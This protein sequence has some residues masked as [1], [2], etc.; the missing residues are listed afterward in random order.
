MPHIERAPAFFNFHNNKPNRSQT[1]INMKISIIS[2]KKITHN[3]GNLLFSRQVGY[4]VGRGVEHQ[5]AVPGSRDKRCSIVDVLCL[6]E[7]QQ[8]AL[9]R[10]TVNSALLS[11][12]SQRDCYVRHVTSAFGDEWFV[13]EAET[14]TVAA[15]DDEA[16]LASYVPSPV[17]K[18]ATLQFPPGGASS[19]PTLE[20]TQP[21]QPPQWPPQ[22]YVPNHLPKQLPKRLQFTPNQQKPRLLLPRPFLQKRNAATAETTKGANPYRP[23]TTEEHQKGGRQAGVSLQVEVY[24][25]RQVW[26]R[27]GYPTVGQGR[28]WKSRR[29]DEKERTRVQA[30]WAAFDGESSRGF[31]I[32]AALETTQQI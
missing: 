5:R 23:D 32:H 31:W 13:V 27:G 28:K 18:S 8:S 30:V 24:G 10:S 4:E 16:A 22:P 11:V 29:E 12:P 26:R 17:P 2:E 21:L 3:D 14:E 25:R 19:T 15:G 1:P 6:R 9:F 7:G 20:G